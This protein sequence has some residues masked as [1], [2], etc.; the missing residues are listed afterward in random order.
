M[1]ICDHYEQNNALKIL[2]KKYEYKQIID[3][4]EDCDLLFGNATPNEI[5]K[6]ISKRFNYLGWGDRI[7]IKGSNLTISYFKNKV[8]ICFQLGNVAR[9]YA[10]VL[11]LALLINSSICDV[12]VIIV[13]DSNI[14]KK[15]GE[16]YA[17]FDRL[18][19]EMQV[20]QEIINFPIIIYAISN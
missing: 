18:S 10:D 15:L 12:G 2:E 19:R 1:K 16:N 8:G 9:T 13:P 11:K 17:R 3:V 4:I 20:F 7:R 6:D 14:S 5:K